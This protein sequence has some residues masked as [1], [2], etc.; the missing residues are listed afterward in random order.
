MTHRIS[1]CRNCQR[2]TAQRPRSK[3]R[4]PSGQRHS[5]SPMISSRAERS[6]VMMAGTTSLRA[7]CAAACGCSSR[8]DR[9]GAGR[10]ARPRPLQA[11]RVEKTPTTAAPAASEGLGDEEPAAPPASIAPSARH[12]KGHRNGRR[13][14][15]VMGTFGKIDIAVP[16]LADAKIAIDLTCS[17]QTGRDQQSSLHP[18]AW[19]RHAGDT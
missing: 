6:C 2:P 16:R 4:R 17:L 8:R 19:R 11:A 1:I 12:A 15:T 10:S 7:K 3:S 18:R 9:S 5:R 14:R 13:V